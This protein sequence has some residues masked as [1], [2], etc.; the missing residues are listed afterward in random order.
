MART[1]GDKNFTAREKRL[2]AQ[3]GVLEA[4]MSTLREQLKVKDVRI[5]ELRDKLKA[6]G[7]EKKTK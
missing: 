1:K 4:R 7:S 2:T 6:K 5:R 3:K